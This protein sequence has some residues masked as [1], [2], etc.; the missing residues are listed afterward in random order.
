MSYK[1]VSLVSLIT[2][3][4]RNLFLPHIQRPFV[5]EWDQISSFFDSLMKNYPIQTLLFWKTQSAIKTRKFL[6]NIGDEVD[7]SDFYEN[8]KSQSGV[9]KTLV[10]DGQQ[11]LQTLFTIFYGTFKNKDIYFN[12]TTGEEELE[13]GLHYQLVY[14]TDLKLPFVK[15]SA[16]TN[17][18]RN[19][20]DIADE[21]NDVL[22]KLPEYN[23]D[24]FRNIERR[25]RKNISQ[26]TSIIREDKS[27]WVEELD[28][29][30]SDYFDYAKVLDIF[31][32]VN[33]GGTKLSSADLMFA[34]MKE[35]WESIEE[36]IDD[37]AELINNS[38]K[39]DF[40]KDFVLK[41]LKVAINRGASTDPKHFTGSQGEQ[42]LNEL[43]DNWN[44]LETGFTAFRDF[45]VNDLRLYSEKVIKSYNSL[46][47]IYDYLARI[48]NPSE[49]NKQ[50]MK[51]YFY[52][53]QLYNWYSSS[54]DQK[55]DNCHNIIRNRVDF[56][57][58]EL[59][60]YFKSMGKK[61]DFEEDD[62]QNSKFKFIILNLTYVENFGSSPF[63]VAYKRNEP[64]IDHI[65]PKSKLA[66]LGLAP[67]EINSIGNFRFVGQSDNN[68]K[69]AQDPAS[70]FQ[71][72]KASG[73][74]I[75]KHLMLKDFCDNTS[76]L[77]YSNYTEFLKRRSYV[78]A[79]I[80]KKNINLI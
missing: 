2:E 41:A 17:D 55:I 58:A 74:N 8:L 26:L 78:I 75:E 56:P 24:N 37:I 60:N 48:P 22:C 80:C 6:D 51:A 16:L 9:E 25:V 27:L 42:I 19:S 35:G 40:G 33:S 67:N 10:L 57:L 76:L 7:L 77:D 31:I 1:P 72:L 68:R 32:R 21:I 49:I 29:I 46:I 52:A 34:I 20:E 47:P 43:R 44:R 54:T 36:N 3:K 79:D 4:N 28:G 30:S 18:R 5:W 73:I 14:G 11:R 39:V 64:N 69:R 59:K 63:D 13:N 15:L 62:L 65:F 66:R 53:A 61:V 45:V 23:N 38:G 50:R 71:S 70:Y 12:I